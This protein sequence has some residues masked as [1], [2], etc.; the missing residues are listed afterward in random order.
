[1]DGEDGHQ[2][3]LLKFA[4]GANPMDGPTKTDR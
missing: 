3:R 2:L 1:M 4:F